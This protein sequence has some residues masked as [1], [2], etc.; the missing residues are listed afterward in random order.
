MIKH[1]IYLLHISTVESLDFLIVAAF[2]NFIIIFKEI[3]S[4][5][6]KYF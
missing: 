5:I 3:T 4:L 2:Y 1:L 6:I